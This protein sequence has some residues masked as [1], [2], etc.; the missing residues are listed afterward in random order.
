MHT[1]ATSEPHTITWM[2]SQE[3]SCTERRKQESILA[4]KE[5]KNRYNVLIFPGTNPKMSSRVLD[6]L[7]IFPILPLKARLVQHFNNPTQNHRKQ[8]WFFARLNWGEGERSPQ[9]FINYFNFCA[10]PNLCLCVSKPV[11]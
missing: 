8:L 2:Q 6:E 3:D 9:T 11:V 7:Q 4:H 5:P 1:L 10:H